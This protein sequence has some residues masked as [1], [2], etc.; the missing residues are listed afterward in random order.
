MKSAITIS[1]V[2]EAAT[3]PFVFH[4]HG[5]AGLELTDACRRAAEL[6][7]DGVEIIAAAAREASAA[8]RAHGSSLA[9]LTLQFSLANP[10]IATTVAGSAKLANIHSWAEWA[11]ESIDEQ[12]LSDVQAIFAAVTN[13]GHSE[14]LPE[15][16]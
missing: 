14:G 6:G 8:C 10:D 16:N 3:G 7:F 13:I 1:L 5:G 11:A 15:N 12:V 4:C 2:P 9:K